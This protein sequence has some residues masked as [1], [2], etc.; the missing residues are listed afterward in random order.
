MPQP[1]IESCQRLSLRIEPEEK[2]LL[3]R[4]V[5][6]QGTTLTSFVTRSSLEAARTV[7]RRAERVALSERDSL[8]V[9]EVLENPP[10]PKAELLKAAEALPKWG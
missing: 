1:S 10:A 5:A 8:Y 2:A 4:A 7:V 3:M 6:L 9:L